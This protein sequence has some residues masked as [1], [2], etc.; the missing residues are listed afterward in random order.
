[1]YNL[2]ISQFNISIIFLANIFYHCLNTTHFT[3]LTVVIILQQQ[4][5]L[6]NTNPAIVF[7]QSESFRAE[8]NMRSEVLLAIHEGAKV[9][10]LEDVEDWIK[11][12]LQNGSIGWIPRSSVQPISFAKE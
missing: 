11:I 9:F 8:P 3:T 12:K 4:N 6:H 10:I 7:V 5:T 1:M 2:L